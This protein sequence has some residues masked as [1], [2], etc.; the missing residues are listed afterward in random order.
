MFFKVKTT[1]E[2]LELVQGFAPVGE[3]IVPLDKAFGRVLRKDIISPEDLPGF[4]RTSVDGY[5]IRAKDSFGATESLP[6]LL[7]IKG[8][9]GMG[10][11]PSMTVAAGQAVKI[12]TGGMVPK[13]AD[14]VV[15]V[16]YCHLMDQTTVE[17]SRAIS[18]QENVIQ[19]DD[20]F[21]KGAAVLR[22]GWKLRSQDVGVLA[23]LGV[24][25]VTVHR[26]PRV[27]IISTG[28]EV[29]PVQ[30]KPKPGQVR[31]INTYT[32]SAFCKEG[33]AEPV[34]L[35]LCP[36]DFEQLR[37]MLLKGLETADTVWISGGSSVG[38][39]DLTLK[40]FESIESTE[41]L[42]HG[43]S[44]SP[45]KPTI[46]ARK[47]ATAVFGLPGHTASAMVVAEV[48]LAPFLARLGGETTFGERVQNK[49]SARLSRNIE[50]ASGRDDFIRVRLIQKDGEWIAEPIFG[51][52]GLISTLVEADG[53]LRIDRNT[54][55]LYQG[56]QVEVM[57]F[58]TV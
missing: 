10:Q 2:V 17:V 30:E 32:L 26:K 33:G 20:D 43:I 19:P 27:A 53:L 12:S 35:G 40:V 23:G 25:E 16:E 39:R 1:E 21:K 48:F 29:I 51:K 8:E 4:P 46:I 41:L 47:G 18:P 38:T 44:I 34:P 28:D 31:D 3:E 6:A 37:N 36:D 22:K 58:K 55:G 42:V 49:V 45:G 15:M 13:G 14:S 9:V 7:E 57:K 52:S 5:A 54:E 24:T 50:S 56:Q 11:V